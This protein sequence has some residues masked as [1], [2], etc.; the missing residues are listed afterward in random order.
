MLNKISCGL[1]QTLVQIVLINIVIA[2]K[3]NRQIE[4]IGEPLC[5]GRVK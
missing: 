3:T 4:K 5:D 1:V 2:L